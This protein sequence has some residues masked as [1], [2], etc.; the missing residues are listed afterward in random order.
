MANTLGLSLCCA[1]ILLAPLWLQQIFA[2]DAGLAAIGGGKISEAQI[3]GGG[4]RG[5]PGYPPI[6]FHSL[7]YSGVLGLH[8][9]ALATFVAFTGTDTARLL[10][11]ALTLSM[12]GC[13]LRLQWSHPWNGAEPAGLGEMP[14][15]LLVGLIGVVAAGTLL[16]TS[17]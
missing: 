10:V 2:D 3:F 9:M 8:L 7:A 6:L 15:P 12:L 16:D 14:V 4:S 11:A 17:P 5:P 1:S 13:L